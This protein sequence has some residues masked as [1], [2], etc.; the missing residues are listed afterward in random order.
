MKTT[1]PTADL[2]QSPRYK[3]RI[4][5]TCTTRQMFVSTYV[6]NISRGGLFVRTDH[7][8]PIHSEVVL[9]L[10]LPECAR[11]L[12]VTGRVAWTYDIRKED[13]RIV[14]G[15]GIKFVAMAATDRDFL[16]EYLDALSCAVATAT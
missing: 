5:V 8:F 15:M 6:T 12:Q 1:V 10:A 7:P 4:S 13:G 16:E 3:V 2:R 9:T 11:S 14:P